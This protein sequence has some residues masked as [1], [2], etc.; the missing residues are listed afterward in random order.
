MEFSQEELPMLISLLS[1]RMAQSMVDG[2]PMPPMEGILS[3][4]ISGELAQEDRDLLSG[5]LRENEAAMTKV[6]AAGDADGQ[7]LDV[8]TGISEGLQEKLEV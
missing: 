6:A 3:R 1:Q 7:M 4:M 8:L 5:L 2:T